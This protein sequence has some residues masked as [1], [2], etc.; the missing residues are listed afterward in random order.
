[1]IPDWDTNTVFFSDQ[2][3][4]RHPALLSAL[5]AILHRYDIPMHIIPS[6]R[7]IW[8][9]D[10]MPLQCDEAT[11]RKFRYRPDYLKDFPT[12]IT[13]ASA[14]RLPFMQRYRSVPLTLDGGNAVASRKYVVITDKIYQENPG[15]THAAVRASLERQL[16]RACIIVPKEPGDIIGHADG[17]VRFLTDE[18]VVVNDYSR[19]DPDYGERLQK[20]LA[21][22]GLRWEIMPYFQEADFPK[23][24]PSA[25][26][27][28]TNFL[29]VG[30]L[31]V[32]PTYGDSADDEAIRTLERLLPTATVYPLDSRVLAREGGVL[33]CVSWTIKKRR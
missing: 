17:I 14:C 18:L 22:H 24:I 7:D 5:L 30:D 20:T 15:L 11:F 1:M 19:I 8:C 3:E 28:Y 21:K 10:Y 29:R 26:G 16:A 27:N 2:M 4:S 12:L 25:V 31:I 23:G 32:V 33:N 13:P 9:R 6:A